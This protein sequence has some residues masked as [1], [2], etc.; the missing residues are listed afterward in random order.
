M[1]TVFSTQSCCQI[2]AVQNRLQISLERIQELMLI[3]LQLRGKNGIGIADVFP[4]L[5]KVFGEI[6][7]D[8]RRNTVWFSMLPSVMLLIIATARRKTSATLVHLLTVCRDFMAHFHP[9][10]NW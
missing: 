5:L 3:C 1:N 2:F 9:H 7:E 6:R 10:M 4:L 8:A